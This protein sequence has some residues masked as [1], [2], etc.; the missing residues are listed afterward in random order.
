ML[1]LVQWSM[2]ENEQK[3]YKEIGY[4]CCFIFAN[5]QVKI[6]L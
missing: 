2:C 5:D 1:Y 3:A 6:I 4:I